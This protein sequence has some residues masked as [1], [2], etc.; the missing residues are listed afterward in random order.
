MSPAPGVVVLWIRNKARVGTHNWTYFGPL[1]PSRLNPQLDCII[2]PEQLGR[3]MLGPMRRLLSP[4]RTAFLGGY[5]EDNHW[6]PERKIVAYRELVVG[7]GTDQFACL[8]LAG[9]EPS[10]E[11]PLRSMDE[12]F[13][14]DLI[15]CEAQSLSFDLRTLPEDLP[16]FVRELYEFCP[17]P[18]DLGWAQSLEIWQ[19]LIARHMS[20]FL[21][22]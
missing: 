10:R 22:W 3:E 9:M 13:G 17:D 11:A 5:F 2:L 7:P 19:E 18:V 8:S 1:L 4:D 14:I 20:V 15:V 12:R 21:H 16:A 6:W